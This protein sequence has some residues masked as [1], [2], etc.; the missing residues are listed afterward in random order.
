MQAD[1]MLWSALAVAAV[2]GLVRLELSPAWG[3]Q[4][5]SVARGKELAER[6][7][8]GCHR[9]NDNQGGIVQGTDVPSFR[10]LALRPQ[11]TPESLLAFIM[12]PRHPMPAIPLELNEIRDVV[13]YIQSLK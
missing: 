10:A 8:A 4:P 7:C 12:T 9:V 3:Q 2:L 5:P 11:Q 1:R 6:L 13:A